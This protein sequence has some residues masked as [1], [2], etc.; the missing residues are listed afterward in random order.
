MYSQDLNCNRHKV[1]K[2]ATCWG[3]TWLASL[4]G[5]AYKASKNVGPC[6][7]IMPLLTLIMFNFQ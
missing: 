1:L 6:L 4:L 2:P 7:I 3:S 5:I